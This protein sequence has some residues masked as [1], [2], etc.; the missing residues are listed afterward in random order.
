WLGEHHNHPLLYPA[1]LIGLAAV[2]SRTRSIRLG[3]GVLLLPLYHPLA[4]AEE[5][6]MVDVISG[7]RLI[8]GVG[9]GY[10]PEE[11]SAFGYSIKQRGSRLDCVQGETCCKRRKLQS[12]KCVCCGPAVWHSGARLYCL[13]VASSQIPLYST[14]EIR[15]SSFYAR[16]SLDAAATRANLDGK[17]RSNTS[18]FADDSGPSPTSH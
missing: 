8:L 9:A 7:G 18:S 1:P 11:F 14:D 13:F 2:A 3:T 5:A 10:A 6:A 12:G 16:A 17:H 15:M 4:V